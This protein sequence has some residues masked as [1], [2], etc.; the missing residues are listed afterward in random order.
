MV[1]S[2]STRSSARMAFDPT[3]SP[4]YKV[5]QSVC[6]DDDD[7][8]DYSIQLHIYSSE[9][10]SWSVCSDR[11]SIMSFEGFNEG[12]Y[13][14]DAIHWLN[15]VFKDYDHSRQLNVYEM[16]NGYLEW[17]VKYIVNLDNIWTSVLE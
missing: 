15:R 1:P 9:T 4:H 12:V 7:G 3:K 11:F 14:N 13:W 8:P 6:L 2:K 10:S 16:R 5:I 17:L